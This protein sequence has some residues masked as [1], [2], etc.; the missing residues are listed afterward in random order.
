MPKTIEYLTFAGATGGSPLSPAVRTGDFVWVSGQ[1]PAGADGVIVGHEITAQ[2]KQVMANIE[3]ALALA[4][5]TLDDICKTT[6]WLQDAR[7]FRAFNTTY[8]GFFTKGLPART[9]SE[10][11]LM[12]NILI[13]I[14]A[15]AYK[16]QD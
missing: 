6:V 10:A 15:V 2:T 16:P 8:A 7:D 4:G 14:E 5:C 3:K 12:A 1:I 13:E 11:R 9:T